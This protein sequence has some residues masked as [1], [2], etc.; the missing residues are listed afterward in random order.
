MQIEILHFAPDRKGSKIGYVD[1]KLTYSPEKQEIFRNVAFF[2]KDGKNWLSV[3]SVKRDDKWL[4]SYERKPST[5]NVF[6][7]V[8][9]DLLADIKTKSVFNEDGSI[10]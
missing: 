5:N 6:H 7:E 1:F 4:P 2:E 8:I 10:F 9:K 3:S